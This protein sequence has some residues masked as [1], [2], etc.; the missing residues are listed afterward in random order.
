MG[1]KG[2]KIV[3][4]I[5]QKIAVGEVPGLPVSNVWEAVTI[6]YQEDFFGLS[7]NNLFVFS[8]FA[9]LRSRPRDPVIRV[10]KNRKIEVR[11]D[12][13]SLLLA[14][15]AVALRVFF[16]YR[17]PLAVRLKS[18][19]LRVRKS[20]GLRRNVQTSRCHSPGERPSR[21]TGQARRRWRPWSLRATSSPIPRFTLCLS[22]C[23]L[24]SMIRHTLSRRVLQNATP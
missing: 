22:A 17:S 11:S 23:L 8:F 20:V 15:L 21:R 2:T 4:I 7:T 13:S 6:W 18:I 14:E 12:R 5:G 3:P 24:S 16:A 10:I 1:L 19:G 9:S